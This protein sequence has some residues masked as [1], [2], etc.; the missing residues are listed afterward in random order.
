VAVPVTLG[1]HVLEAPALVGGAV[2]TA[3]D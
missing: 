1:K 2:E 3:V